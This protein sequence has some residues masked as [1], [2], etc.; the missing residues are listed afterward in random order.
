MKKLV[1]TL[2]LLVPSVCF[3][4]GLQA[5]FTGSRFEGLTR[6]STVVEHWGITDT[7]GN[8]LDM[9]GT[10][11]L[12]YSEEFDNAAWTKSDVT[13]TAD[14]VRGPGSSTANA[15]LLAATA[16]DSYV[17]Q[18]D[19]VA[20]AGDDYT[21]SFYLRSVAG[22]VNLSIHL[23]DQS[24]GTILATEALTVNSLWK[25][26]S[27][28]GTL[29]TG[30]TDAGCTIGGN[31]TFSTG[32]QIY[33]V[34]A[35]GQVNDE[36]RTGPGVYHKTEADEMIRLDPAP[37]NAPVNSLAMLQGSNGNKLSA[38]YHND[39][40][41]QYY[42][43]LDA[44][45]GNV[46]DVFEDDHTITVLARAPTDADASWEAP[47][48]K[49]GTGDGVQIFKDDT[50]YY[51]AYYRG[52][53]GT[54]AVECTSVAAND[55]QWHVIQ[56]VRSGNSATIWV[57]GTQ[58][59]T[60]DITGRGV[61][62]TRRYSIA[63]REAGAN[64]FRGY[65][66][67]IRVDTEA[68]SADDRN[69]DLR[70][71]QGIVSSAEQDWTIV[72][73]STS[74]YNFTAGSSDSTNPLVGNT[75]VGWMRVADGVL[76]EAGSSNSLTYSEEID[77]A[78]YT[79]NALTTVSANAIV[80]PDG[81]TTA[82]GLVATAVDTQHGVTRFRTVTAASWTLSVYAKPGDKNWIYLSDDTVA[83]ATA[84]FNIANGFIGTV[85]AGATAKLEVIGDGWY[86]AS[87]AFTGTAA[88]HTLRIYTANADID[89][90]F[91]GDASTI[92]T[93][94][95][96]VQ[97]ESE[98]FP[99]SYIQT[100]SGTVSRLT[101]SML[102]DPHVASTTQ[103]ILP[104]S[105][106]PTCTATEFTVTFEAKCHFSS[107]SDL[108][109]YK[110]FLGICGT[111]PTSN[112]YVM[113]LDTDGVIYHYMY[114]STLYWV[115]SSSDPVDFSEWHKYTGYVDMT[116]MT[117]LALYID[118]TYSVNSDSGNLSGG[119][120]T[121]DTTSATIRIGQDYDLVTNTFCKFRNLRIY[122]KKVT[123]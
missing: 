56:V 15:D 61:D 13:V 64:A 89:N 38:T 46:L 36:W 21:C 71:L 12:Q 6:E 14:Q 99:T 41:P 81:A 119:S 82:D 25:R 75:D 96:G 24:H 106:C 52:G 83:N 94:L 10:N 87:I 72:K 86:R 78:A 63:A 85:G 88:S 48:S 43:M 42:S 8:L 1:A 27:V 40:L 51:S 32:E 108:E 115:G 29:A 116:D 113:F 91:A 118:D 33:A 35:Q 30:D 122:N 18:D 111:T 98:G 9:K 22:T 49:G 117:K 44:A 100:T 57:D 17:Y 58:G 47:F 90:D 66:G 103:R 26:Y 80:A 120:D 65:V 84:Y 121:F 109:E 62:G 73:N 74:S 5:S 3:G 55:S 95:W 53:A 97:L 110:M 79:K 2:L 19:A 11:T 31:S 20:D 60:E 69:K 39:A 101:E 76:V 102:L 4:D 112:R 54:V 34:R 67:Y 7:S 68:L 93:Y 107:S 123:P 114:G 105:Y 77:N 28:S 16:A 92:N 23:Y 104:D 50:Q 70:T 45:T 59:N 37:V